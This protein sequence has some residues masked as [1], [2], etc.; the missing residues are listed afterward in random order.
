MT[1]FK[2]GDQTYLKCVG[3]GYTTFERGCDV[4]RVRQDKIWLENGD[5]PYDAKTGKLIADLPSLGLS[6][7]LCV[8]D[9]DIARAKKEIEREA[10]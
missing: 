9:A 7:T 4:L 10:A 2:K 1:K 8:T 6:V 5:Y 3:Y